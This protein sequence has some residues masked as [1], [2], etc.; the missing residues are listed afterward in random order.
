MTSVPR[1]L[2]RSERI[3]PAPAPRHTSADARDRRAGVGWASASARKP[4]ISAARVGLLGALAGQRRIGRVQVR[5]H[6]PGDEPQ[7]GAQRP[8]R[9]PGDPR[10]VRG[11]PLDHRRVQQHARHR[12]QPEP[13][14]V[15]RRACRPPTAGSWP[16]PGA[17]GPQPATTC[18]ANAAASAGVPAAGFHRAGVGGHISVHTVIHTERNPGGHAPRVRRLRTC[19]QQ[20]AGPRRPHRRRA[21]RPG[22]G[23]ARHPHPAARALRLGRLPLPRRPARSCTARTGSG[24]ASGPARPSAAWSPTTRSTTTGNGS[25][26]TAGCASWSPSWKTSPSPSPTSAAAARPRARRTRQTSS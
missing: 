6:P 16:G 7:V 19:R 3:S 4:A 18:R 24:P 1:A 17:S 11:E 2:R 20:P 5:H 23:A 8:P 25:T 9:R 12:L 21:G 14:A 26:T 15:G 22:P 13:D 10:R